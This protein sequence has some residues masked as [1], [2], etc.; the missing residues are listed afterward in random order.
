[1]AQT[2]G[3]HPDAKGLMGFGGAGVLEIVEDSQAETCRAVHKVRFP[4]AVYVLHAFRKKSKSGIKTPTE[5][6][7]LIRRAI[8]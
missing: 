2:G 6:M 3:M 4:S 1:M 7:D 5:D 8:C